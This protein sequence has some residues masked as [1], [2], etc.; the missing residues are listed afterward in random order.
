MQ[1]GEALLRSLP[2]ERLFTIRFRSTLVLL[3]PLATAVLNHPGYIFNGGFLSM[4]ATLLLGRRAKRVLSVGKAPAAAEGDGMSQ[5]I[6][7]R[8]SVIVPAYNHVAYIRECIDSALNQTYPDAEVVVWTTAPLTGPTRS[9][10]PTGT[11]SRRSG[12][13]TGTQAARNTA[14]RASTG[15]F[16]A[17]LDSDDVWLPHKLERQIPVF[18][19]HPETAL[20]YAYASAVDEQG[21]PLES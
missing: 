7:G 10:R 18:E 12:R 19:E 3:E 21:G 9:R 6:P 5:T 20:V 4:L 15:E 8:V 1:R 14:I 13:R 16:I 2:C 17:L 11:G